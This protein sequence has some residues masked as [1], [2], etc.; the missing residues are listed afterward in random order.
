VQIARLQTFWI[1]A[2]SLALAACSKPIPPEYRDYIGDWQA[3][4]MS[5]SIFA[6]GTIRYER[7][8]GHSTRSIEGPIQRFD[9]SDFLVGIG[10]LTTTF[11]VSAR[12]HEYD[13]EWRMT[14]DGVELA[15]LDTLRVER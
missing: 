2:A 4:N 13:G 1:V 10:P 11:A 8:E 7:R 9:G 3:A 12:P 15:K 6:D 14:V 5:L